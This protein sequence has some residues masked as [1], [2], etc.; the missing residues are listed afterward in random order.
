MLHIIY[1]IFSGQSSRPALSAFFSHK[2]SKST[3]IHRIYLVNF[4][5]FSDDIKNAQ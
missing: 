2:A 4:Y 1:Y 3:H 5:L